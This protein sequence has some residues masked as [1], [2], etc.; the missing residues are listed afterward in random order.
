MLLALGLSCASC[1]GTAAVPLAPNVYYVAVPITES[2]D[3]AAARDLAERQAYRRCEGDGLEPEIQD[4]QITGG[5][6]GEPDSFDL[7]FR[8][9]DGAASAD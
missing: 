6:G 7:I 5:E 4:T 8:C 1:M 9:S 3:E 2:R